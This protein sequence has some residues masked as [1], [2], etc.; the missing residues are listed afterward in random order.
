MLS[1]VVAILISQRT[2]DAPKFQEVLTRHGCVIKIRL[3]LHEVDDCREEGL[4]ILH[5][6]GAEI[7]LEALV[8][9]INALSNIR[10]QILKL[11][12]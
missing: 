9:D 11:D 8:A 12:F 7:A 3:G 1:A 2:D 6:C 5:V 4:V 10:A